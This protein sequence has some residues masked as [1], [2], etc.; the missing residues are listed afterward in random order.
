MP[1]D[2]ELVACDEHGEA[3]LTFLC[4]HLAN[5][6]AQEWFSDSPSK[7]NPWPDSWCAECDVEFLK[8]GEWND[9]NGHVLDIRIFCHRCYEQARAQGSFNDEG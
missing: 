5:N 7:A 6:P 9:K 8:H 1:S 4:V 2:R 3:Y